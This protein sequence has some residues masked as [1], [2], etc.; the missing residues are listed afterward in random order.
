[1]LNGVH[2]LLACL[3]VMQSNGKGLKE[4][5]QTWKLEQGKQ[6]G[7]DEE[8]ARRFRIFQENVRWIEEYNA[9]GGT[10]HHTVGL[11]P[12][13]D[14][15]SQE[16]QA[17]KQGYHYRD[18]Q[19]RLFEPVST[20]SAPPSV[21]WR[22]HNAVTPV[23]NEAQCGG[24]CWAFAAIG[25]IEGIHAIRTGEL[26]ALSVQELLEC[27]IY[28]PNGCTNGGMV[29]TA[30]RWIA[31]NGGIASAA[32]YPYHPKHVQECRNRT[33]PP[34]ITISGYASVPSRNEVDLQAAVWKQ[35]I[36]VA[37]WA[38]T[39]TAGNVWQ[40][41]KSGI[42]NDVAHC[43]VTSIDQLDH[44]VLI[45]GYGSVDDHDYWIIKND[46]GESWGERGYIRLGRQVH[47][48]RPSG[49]CGVTLDANFPLYQDS[50]N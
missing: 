10:R 45:V 6:Y 46:W 19:G 14:M 7:S 38:L 2:L 4:R 16:F 15:T 32:D 40:H 47:G 41:Y 12:F 17:R 3:L 37:V 49:M 33:I 42:M 8:H 27:D 13:S 9:A 50:L 11:G 5:F 20:A 44:A 35:P 26:L 25:A 21:D 31:E 29:N 23:G 28:S 22:R 39:G 34:N 43:N 48:A 30:Y 18:H 1:M 24:A 36:S